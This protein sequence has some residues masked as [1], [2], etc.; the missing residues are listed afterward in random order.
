MEPSTDSGTPSVLGSMSLLHL[1]FSAPTAPEDCETTG[2]VDG[3]QDD[4]RDD[5]G[6]VVIDAAVQE[7][8]RTEQ[9]DSEA[10]ECWEQPFG[11][12]QGEKATA[13]EET[14][15]VIKAVERDKGGEE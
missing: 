9:I 2:T 8:V 1:F 5:G 11:S 12:K 13:A 15:Q 6:I 14:E 4:K 7:R 3:S 10:R